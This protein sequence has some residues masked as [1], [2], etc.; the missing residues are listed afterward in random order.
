MKKVGC[1]IGKFLPQHIGH[2]SVMDKALRECERVIVVLA[3]NP[4]K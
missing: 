1:F 2:L 4:E 3:E